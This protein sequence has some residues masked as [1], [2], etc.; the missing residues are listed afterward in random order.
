MVESNHGAL[1]FS[2]P[3]WQS[4]FDN[5]APEAP[6]EARNLFP[7]Q[8]VLGGRLTLEELEELLHSGYLQGTAN[9]IANPNQRQASALFLMVDVG[10]YQGPDSSRIHVGY[11]SQI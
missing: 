11:G 1:E 8:R 5:S 7:R 2:H 9:A 4:E 10:S 6:A 3:I